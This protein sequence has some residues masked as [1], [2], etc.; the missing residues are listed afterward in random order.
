[1][2]VLERTEVD[3]TDNY[4]CIDEASTTLSLQRAIEEYLGFSCLLSLRAQDW[5]LGS[6]NIR[7]RATR[8]AQGFDLAANTDE[9]DPDNDKPGYERLGPLEADSYVTG[10]ADGVPGVQV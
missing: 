1:M 7:A 9:T 10:S 2:P 4:V 8:R 3:P 5:K 6:E